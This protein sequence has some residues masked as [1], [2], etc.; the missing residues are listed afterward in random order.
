MLSALL[1][2]CSSNTARAPV[3]ERTQSSEQRPT[4]HVVER[5]DTLFSIAWRYGFDYKRLAHANKIGPPYRIVPGQKI[6]LRQ[7]S[8]SAVKDTASATSGNSKPIAAN[9]P[10]ASTSPPKTTSKAPVSAKNDDNLAKK[11][12]KSWVWPS[13]GRLLAKFRGGKTP[14]LGIDLDGVLGEPVFASRAGTVVYAGSGL[15]GYGNLLIIK[16][17]TTF[18]SAY[19]HNSRLLVTEGE[20]VKAS[21]KIAEKGSSGTDTVKL[22]FQIRK[23]G[24]PVNPLRYLPPK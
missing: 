7:S 6:R 3:V 21:Q 2:S 4:E 13:K 19:A 20:S 24:K 16:H 8:K 10:K 5:G 17:D 14:H 23:D 22:H 15:V 11:S 18:L 12:Q 9:Q 1:I